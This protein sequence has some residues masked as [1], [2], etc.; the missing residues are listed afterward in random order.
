V[1]FVCSVH[2]MSIKIVFEKGNYEKAKC[3]R[4]KK[5]IE[6]GSSCMPG[7]DPIQTPTWVMYKVGGLNPNTMSEKRPIRLGEK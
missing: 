7:L 2:I 4:C 5:G 1:I 6:G 3:A